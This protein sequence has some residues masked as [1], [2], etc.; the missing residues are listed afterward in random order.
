M[1]TA[2]RDIILGLLILTLFKILPTE[3]YSWIHIW[4]YKCVRSFKKN[5]LVVC[6]SKPLIQTRLRVEIK[7]SIKR[8]L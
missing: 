3:I 7:H 8:S 5:D 6:N 1:T 2:L 4:K